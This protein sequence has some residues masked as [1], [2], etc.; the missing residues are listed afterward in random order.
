MLQDH[1]EKMMKEEVCSFFINH[2][3]HFN[4]FYTINKINAAINN[5]TK[6][7]HAFKNEFLFREQPIFNDRP[8]LDCN[9]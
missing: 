6:L 2:I 4:K 5:I 3:P 9:D 1:K 7:V 8:S